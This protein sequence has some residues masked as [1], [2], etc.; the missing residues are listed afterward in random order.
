MMHEHLIEKLQ[1]A[2]QKQTEESFQECCSRVADIFAEAKENKQIHLTEFSTDNCELPVDTYNYGPQKKYVNLI[3]DDISEKVPAELISGPSPGQQ[4]YKVKICSKRMLFLLAKFL[5][6][7]GSLEFVFGCVFMTVDCS[8]IFFLYP[9]MEAL[10][11]QGVIDWRINSVFSHEKLFAVITSMWTKLATF[12][13]KRISPGPVSLGDILMNP[14]TLNTVFINLNK[15]CPL[16]DGQAV[17]DVLRCTKL[18]IQLLLPRLFPAER[19]NEL[20]DFPLTAENWKTCSANLE[21]RVLEVLEKSVFEQSSAFE[22]RI[23]WGLTEQSVGVHAI[24]NTD[25]C[26]DVAGSVSGETEWVKEKENCAQFLNQ[27]TARKVVCENDAG[28][29][30][31]VTEGVKE[32]EPCAQFLNNNKQTARKV[33]CD[34]VAGMESVATEGVKEKENCAQFLNNKEETA[35]Q[36]VCDNVAGMESVV[37]E[38]VKEK[39]NWA[40]FLNN[41]EQ[42]ARKVECDNVAGMESVVTEG[43]KEKENWAQFFNNKE[44]TARKEV[45]DDVATGGESGVLEK[46]NCAQLLNQKGQTASHGSDSDQTSSGQASSSETQEMPWTSSGEGWLPCPSSGPEW[47]PLREPRGR[48]STDPGTHT[49]PDYTEH[50]TKRKSGGDTHEKRSTTTPSKDDD[51][52]A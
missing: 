18:T 10:L 7:Y 16:T 17:L 47:S 28:S 13:R 27:Q 21:P 33:E 12:H 43:V 8:M 24:A 19:V 6:I 44:Q 2:E 4:L 40:Q 3:G 49:R 25:V 37:A 23:L 20:C 36:V 50:V 15:M 35:R 30:S 22:V 48:F 5:V 9:S 11:W 39:E 14:N 41:K 51:I 42:T 1:H 45:C 29:K 32:K 31:V 26:G 34:N 52:S 46:E 38:G